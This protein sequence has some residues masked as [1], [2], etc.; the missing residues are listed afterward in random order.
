VKRIECGC[1]FQG[2]SLVSVCEIH[3]NHTKAAVAVQAL[4]KPK[5]SGTNKD[6][7]D[8]L[9]IELAPSFVR[10]GGAREL[11]KYVNEI[12]IEGDFE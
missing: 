12:L 2:T 5:R 11:V 9:L 3:A 4:S 8:K 7:R 10:S 6:L 1:E